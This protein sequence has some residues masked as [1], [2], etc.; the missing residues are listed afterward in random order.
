MCLR[1]RKM[2][3]RFFNSNLALN[4]E[5]RLASMYVRA[6]IPSAVVFIASRMFMFLLLER[7][8][9]KELSNLMNLLCNLLYLFDLS[10]LVFE[11]AVDVVRIYIHKCIAYILY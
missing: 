4:S 11:V 7:I 9:F 10:I 8:V 6:I 5:T 1:L 2:A 3:V